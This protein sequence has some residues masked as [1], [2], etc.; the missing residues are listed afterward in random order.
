MA[1]PTHPTIDDKQSS[2]SVGAPGALVSRETVRSESSKN[3]AA[4]LCA[5]EPGTEPAVIPN[6][7]E[8]D[9]QLPVD[10][11]WIF[12][13]LNS[14]NVQ[15]EES[16]I[17]QMASASEQLDISW[18]TGL[19]AASAAG[20]VLPPVIPTFGQSSGSAAATTRTGQ[21]LDEL[22]DETSGWSEWQDMG[23]LEGAFQ[24]SACYGSTMMTG[25]IHVAPLV[26]TMNCDTVPVPQKLPYEPG[27]IPNRVINVLVK[28]TAS[29]DRSNQGCTVATPPRAMAALRSVATSTS[30]LLKYFY[31]VVTRTITAIDDDDNPCRTCWLPA[32]A[33]VPNSSLSGDVATLALL[34]AVQCVSAVHYLNMLRSLKM[35]ADNCDLH[36]QYRNHRSKAMQLSRAAATQPQEGQ[37]PQ[38]RK[39]S[40]FSSTGTLLALVLGSVLDGDAKTVPLMLSTADSQLQLLDT[41]Y[42]SS[43]AR[44]FF[45]VHSIYTFVNGMVRDQMID[46]NKLWWS[47]MSGA[48][49]DP[50]SEKCADTVKVIMGASPMMLEVLAGVH[51]H[52]VRLRA[53]TT[54]LAQTNVVA[55]PLHWEMAEIEAELD[56]IDKQQ[57]D[58][59]HPVWCQRWVDGEQERVRLGHEMYR[60]AIRVY[61]LRCA[62]VLPQEDARIQV[63]VQ[64]FI[65]CIKQVWLGSEVGATWP[66]ILVGCEAREESDRT[67]LLRFAAQCNW[68]GSAPSAIA[69]SGG[70]GRLRVYTC[71]WMSIIGMGFDL[72]LTGSIQA[73][74]Q[75][76]TYFGTP[77]GSLLGILTAITTLGMVVGAFPAPYL[78]N[79]YGRKSGPVV[80]S[81]IIIVAA[82]LQTAAKN[83]GMYIAGRFLTGLGILFAHNASPAM[84]TE[85]APKTE[86]SVALNTYIP[87]YVLGSIVMS[88][89]CYGTV[90]LPSSWS[91]RGPCLLQIAPPLMQLA[92]LPFVPESPRWLI[93]HG[94]PEAAKAIL[95]KYHGGGIETPDVTE[96]FDE[97]VFNTEKQK[98]TPRTSWLDL[99][100]GKSGRIRVAI[101]VF[102]G[103]SS[104]M[105]GNAVVGYYFVS[106]LESIGYTSGKTQTLFSGIVSIWTLIW[107]I[108]LAIVSQRLGRRPL[109]LFGVITMLVTFTILSAANY[110]YTLSVSPALG[111]LVLATYVLYYMG[112]GA[113]WS[114]LFLYPSEL[115]PTQMRSKALGIQ[116]MCD[117]GSLFISLFAS[118]IA[119]DNIGVRY[120]FLYVGLLVIEV[121]FVY[122]IFIETNGSTVEQICDYWDGQMGTPKWFAGP[123]SKN[124]MAENARLSVERMGQ[125]QDAGQQLEAGAA[126]KC[127][128]AEDAIVTVAAL[129]DERQRI[130]P[131]E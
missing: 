42:A 94:K 131:R 86:R 40:I 43:S 104:Q 29:S 19:S 34:N 121:V 89:T 60:I 74:S 1:S 56:T 11:A 124:M 107:E 3:A 111:K 48:H 126:E 84:L 79:H 72:S 101:L 4:P 87:F 9:T 83:V 118:P 75:W 70:W 47:R 108:F 58:G 106:I 14:P 15:S 5:A 53:L 80:G 93:L 98:A 119:I 105:S 36:P 125:Q 90:E 68:N 33:T 113:A 59:D 25:N 13:L 88:W 20:V 77:K 69:K 39:R 112:Y 28:M 46:C 103:I 114:T 26:P 51:N 44:F 17:P 66:L 116:A 122:F 35:P 110:S 117:Y 115:F 6:S 95:I 7:D 2:S 49:G 128:G 81:I 52:I 55:A 97:I 21:T 91:W 65:H 57:Q 92:L 85:F 22:T 31:E 45:A 50:S 130:Q 32:D 76:Q 23:E 8:P 41:A 37:D 109:F 82:I 61:I 100:R 18:T 96:T 123:R 27:Q 73:S 30:E 63:C 120:Y 102:T 71:F 78:N 24:E 67:E 16:R 54:E 62:F 99:I 129:Q 10:E 127:D 64:Q 38:A 12:D